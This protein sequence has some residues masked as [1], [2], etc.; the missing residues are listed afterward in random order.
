M[1]DLWGA[2]HRGTDGIP[3]C[4][5][6]E[7]AWTKEPLG[8]AE[9]SS[10]H[11]HEAAR[12]RNGAFRCHYTGVELNLDDPKHVRYREWEHATPDDEN[13]VVL[14]TALVNRMKCYLNADEFRVMVAEL[15]RHFANPAMAFD[16]SVFPNRPV[17]RS[18]Q[19]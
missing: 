14:A 6:Q 18:R 3:L 9:G 15:A 17:P 19:A 13:S 7:G 2:I 8:G 5:L 16:D 4:P 1:Q 10:I 11:T 12:K